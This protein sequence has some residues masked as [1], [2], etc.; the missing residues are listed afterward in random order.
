MPEVNKLPLNLTVEEVLQQAIRLYGC[1][2]SLTRARRRDLIQSKLQ[3]V[4]LETHKRKKVRQ[5]S[6][7]MA[8][9][10]AF[11]QATIH[12]PR[13]LVLDEPSTGLDPN[14]AETL[15]E[16]IEMEKTRGT[17]ILLCT[18]DLM[19]INAL[20]D[21]FYVMRKGH[22]VGQSKGM[23]ENPL[24]ESIDWGSAYGIQVSGVSEDVLTKLKTHGQLP[25][26]TSLRLEGQM[27][28]LGFDDYGSAS[29][30]LSTFLAKSYLV[31]RFGDGKGLTGAQIR[32]F[33]KGFV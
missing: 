6:K 33:F 24:V 13:L 5:L 9:R 17:T 12:G 23:T 20:C 32:N 28:S 2:P 27:A 18:H 10:L 19:H 14:A 29:Q 4:G 31:L 21:A 15:I 8:R 26:W 25:P 1:D 3:S 7:G 22:L 30:W 11:A 16:Q